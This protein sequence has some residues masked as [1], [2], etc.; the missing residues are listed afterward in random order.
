MTPEGIRGLAAFDFDGTIT[1]RDTLG[2][3]LASNGRRFALG[4]AVAGTVRGR[5][6]RPELS[7]RDLLK[8]H[9]LQQLFAGMESSVLED[10]G[11]TYAAGLS[12]KYRPEALAHVRHHRERG[13]ELAL[14]TA[15]LGVY[16]RPAAAALGFDH[17]IAVELETDADGTYTGAIEGGTNVR[18]PEKA[19]RLQ[20]VVGD[21]P[22]EVWAY[23]NSSGDDELLAMADHPVWIGRRSR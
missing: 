2:P 1:E 12:S 17:V 22:T 16:A 23:G 4:R 15:S 5:R 20:E 3:F 13:H 21:I 9:V 7:G 14:V 6:D 10:Q 11:R 18:G 19:R 8:H